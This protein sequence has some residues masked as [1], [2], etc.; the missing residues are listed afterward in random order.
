MIDELERVLARVRAERRQARAADRY[1]RTLHQ[2]EGFL[3]AH[4]D[5]SANL[6]HREIGGWRQDVLK[7]CRAVRARFPTPGNQRDEVAA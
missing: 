5:A 7:A 2:V 6:V 3:A 4:S 1:Q